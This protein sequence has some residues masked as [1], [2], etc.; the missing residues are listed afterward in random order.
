M[1]HSFDSGIVFVDWKSNFKKISFG[2][3]LQFWSFSFFFPDA[4]HSLFTCIDIWQFPRSTNTLHHLNYKLKTAHF[5]FELYYRKITT[6]VE[7]SGRSAIFGVIFFWKSFHSF[8]VEFLIGISFKKRFKKNEEVDRGHLVSYL[9]KSEF[10][11]PR[12]SPQ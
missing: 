9:I 1:S 5:R 10:N 7:S 6:N 11:S 12:L 8:S 4:V 3:F 2:W